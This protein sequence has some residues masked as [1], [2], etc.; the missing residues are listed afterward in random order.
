MFWLNVLLTGFCEALGYDLQ[1]ENLSSYY[2]SADGT[3]YGAEPCAVAPVGNNT[4]TCG[5]QT[6]YG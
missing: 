2:L 1:L 5:T 6:I 4:G 3:A